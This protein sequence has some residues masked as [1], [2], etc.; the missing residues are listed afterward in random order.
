MSFKQRSEL[1]RGQL[2]VGKVGLPPLFGEPT[3]LSGGGEVA[4]ATRS[5]FSS[6]WAA[7]LTECI[8]CNDRTLNAPPVS[9]AVMASTI[10]CA[11]VIVVTHGTL[12]CKA[13]RR[14]ACS[15]KWEARPSGVLITSAISPRLI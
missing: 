13:A 6:Y 9:R 12:Y 8:S 7:A 2:V 4:A 14:I 10:A 1:N 11:P 15:S 5:D 3:R